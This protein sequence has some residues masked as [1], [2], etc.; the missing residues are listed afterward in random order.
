MAR[1]DSTTRTARR[2]RRARRGARSW[3]AKR[4]RGGPREPEAAPAR[5]GTRPAST[6]RPASR[7]TRGCRTC[8]RRETG[9]RARPS[10]D[11]GD[12]AIES[13]RARRRH[14]LTALASLRRFVRPRATAAARALR[15]VRRG[16]GGRARP[17]GRAGHAAAGLR[18][19]GV[20]HPVQR[21]GRRRDTAAC[22]GAS[23]SWPISA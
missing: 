9:S 20:R 4:P 21:P 17:S 8:R 22:L 15:A 11:P 18:V 23:G 12:D 14:G 2:T 7:S 6:P 16:A 5:P 10:T 13:R 3:S 19:R 1:F